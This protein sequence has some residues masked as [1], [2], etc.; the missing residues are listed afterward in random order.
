MPI[1]T[2]QRAVDLLELIADLAGR[3][4]DAEKEAALYR[5]WWLEAK[6][7]AEEDAF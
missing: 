3:L 4:K 2:E 1:T 6:E 7:K 5:A